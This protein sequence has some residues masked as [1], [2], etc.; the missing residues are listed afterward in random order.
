MTPSFKSPVRNLQH[1]PSPQLILSQPNHVWSWSNAQDWLLTNY[2]PDLWCERWPHPSS[3]QSGTLNVLQVPNLCFLSQIMSDLD[4]TFRRGP[5]ATT[6]LIYDVKDDP[7]LQVSSQ[8]PSTSSKPPTYT[9]LAKS[10]PIMIKLSGLAPYQLPTSSL[11]FNLTQS[12]QSPVRND[13]HPPSLLEIK[14]IP[15]LIFSWPKPAFT[16]NKTYLKPFF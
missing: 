13:Q 16:F 4:Q 11:M 2:Q 9:F 15:K 5:L 12:F 10:C 7:I 14:T 3:L 1:P 6:N 8:E